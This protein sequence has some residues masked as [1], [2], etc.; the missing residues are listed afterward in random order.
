MEV[1]EHVLSAGRAVLDMVEREWQPL[2][3]GELE[4]RLDQAVEE[5]LESGLRAQLDARPAPSA[6]Y[7]QLLQSRVKGESPVLQTIPAAAAAAAAVPKEEGEAAADSL[8]EPD[9]VHGAAVKYISDLLQSS[10]SRV[11][12]A[13]RARL[14][15][16]HTVLLSLTL[17]SERLSYR[18]VSRR[19][20]L[21]KGNIHRIFFSFC[22]RVNT[23]QQKIIRW[24]EG[25]DAVDALVP[26]SSLLVKDDEEAEEQSVPQVLG[27]LGHARVPIRLPIGKHDVD[28]ALPEVRRMR[29]EAPPDSWLNLELVSDRRG[30]FLHC[31]VSRGSDAE[32]GGALADRLRRKPELMPPGSVLVARAGYPLTARVLTPYATSSPGS[33]EKLFNKTL[34]QHLH[35]LD[36][37]VAGLRARFQK[38]RYLDIGNYERARAVALTAC[39]LHNVFLDIG[40]AAAVQG[41][42]EREETTPL[43]GDVDEEGVRSRDAIAQLLFAKSSSG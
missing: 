34:E 28:S 11:R 29:R 31:R 1:R 15:L 32:R 14:S 24:P 4:L 16:P 19:F 8:Q 36:Q 33:R 5:I 37:A 12:L 30:R 42:V 39:V 38:L 18:C 7:L 6:V 3:A 13:G 17:L 22:K 23:L 10:T 25:Q 26:L 9:S 41:A 40:K 21:E 20:R 35:G 2:S 43:E 27:V